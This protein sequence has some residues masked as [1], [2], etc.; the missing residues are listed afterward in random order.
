MRRRAS[1]RWGNARRKTQGVS[2]GSVPRRL[3]LL[4]AGWGQLTS[5]ENG[6]HDVAP[7]G[8][9]DFELL[10]GSLLLDGFA[11]LP[12]RAVSWGLVCHRSPCPARRVRLLA[13]RR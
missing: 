7:G 1:C 13:G 10:G 5:R 6:G 4:A 11:R 2:E 8:L 9:L 3:T 12:A